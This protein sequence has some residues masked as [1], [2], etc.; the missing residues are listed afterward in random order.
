MLAKWNPFANGGITRS[1]PMPLFDDFFHEAERLFEAPSSLS[2]PQA[3]IFETQDELVLQMDLPGHDPKSVDIKIEGDLLTVQSQRAAP[4]DGKA[5]W[6]RQERSYGQFARTFVLPN[7]VDGSRCEARADNGV[8]T[9]TLPKR[10][11]AKPR[12]IAVK[13]QS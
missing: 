2:L 12:S 9:L 8:L 5:N 13:V 4:A 6:L 10:E 3:D 11:E 1:S 7:T